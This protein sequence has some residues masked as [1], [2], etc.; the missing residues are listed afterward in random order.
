MEV[1]EDGVYHLTTDYVLSNGID[2]DW[3][4]GSIHDGYLDDLR[5]GL[6]YTDYMKKF[7]EI[8]E[9]LE[10]T[11]FSTDIVW[12]MTDG[13]TFNGEE[14]METQL[15]DTSYNELTSSI[16]LLTGAWE[17]FYELKK[18]YQ[19]TDLVALLTLEKEAREAQNHYTINTNENVLQVY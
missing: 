5:N 16:E 9:N 15:D 13:S 4:N 11:E 6:S 12:Y 7:T 8:E 19:C 10:E 1:D 2:Y 18:Q 3:Y 17:T 14:Y